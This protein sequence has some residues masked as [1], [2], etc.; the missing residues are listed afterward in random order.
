M[1]YNYGAETVSQPA[2]KCLV[3]MTCEYLVIVNDKWLSGE[4][5]T[6]IP[7]IPDE[8][9][10]KCINLDAKV[11]HRPPVPT[12]HNSHFTPTAVRQTDSPPASQ[13]SIVAI[14]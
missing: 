5:Q 13:P 3:L 9:L 1:C 10:I 6:G 8:I 11:I 14:N 2:L 7:L 12:T 4:E